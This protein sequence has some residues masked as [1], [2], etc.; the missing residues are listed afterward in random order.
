MTITKGQA[1]AVKMVEDGLAGMT[2][3]TISNVLYSLASDR[4]SADQ[5]EELGNKFGR[6]G[7]MKR[8]EE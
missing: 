3:E 5:L 2:P 4:L 8:R 7:H 1:A 6:A